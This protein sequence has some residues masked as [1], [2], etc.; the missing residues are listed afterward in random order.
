MS[1]SY[2]KWGS[3]GCSRIF[4]EAR[5]ATQ[6]GD[7]LVNTNSVVWYDRLP[8][9]VGVK[10]KSS[11]LELICCLVKTQVTNP[12]HQR[13]FDF[14]RKR[15]FACMLLCCPSSAAF[16][17]SWGTQ[18]KFS[19]AKLVVIRQFSYEYLTFLGKWYFCRKKGREERKW[20]KLNI[21]FNK[22]SFMF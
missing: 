7:F 5:Y 6:T 10:G 16:L 4:G 8:V 19:T 9:N 3:K 20:K 12:T 11:P 2:L 17:E 22:P 21:H 1:K 13:C 14:S 15:E 18:C